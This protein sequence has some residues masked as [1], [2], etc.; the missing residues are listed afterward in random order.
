[1]DGPVDVA[2][3]RRRTPRDG[4]TPL[5]DF[6]YD[7]FYGGAIGGSTV[8]LVFAVVDAIA[9]EPLYTPSL[10]GSVLFLGI[11]PSAVT[12]VR[13]DMVALFTVVHLV[14]FGVLGVVLSAMVQRMHELALHPGLVA[15]FVFL[16]LETGFLGA[17]RVLMQGVVAEIGLVWISLANLL[18]GVAMGVFLLNAHRDSDTVYVKKRAAA[19]AA[20]QAEA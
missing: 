2:V 11:E 13:M 15:L 8:A 6:L 9:H 1:M 16:F 5:A 19:A 20:R 7:A 17:D 10:L 14:T 18:T 3:D 12:E 4:A